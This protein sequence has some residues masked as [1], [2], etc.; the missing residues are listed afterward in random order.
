MPVHKRNEPYLYLYEHGILTSSRL[1]ECGGVQ[2]EGSFRDPHD[3]K[4]SHVRASQRSE[5]RIMR[6]WDV[7]LSQ[8]RRYHPV[9]QSASDGDVIA[10]LVVRLSV[11]FQG[12]VVCHDLHI[13]A[14]EQE[15]IVPQVTRN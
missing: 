4:Q 8:Q 10:A 9:L 13:Q 3:C 5:E 1:I 12:F 14:V 7:G 11:T 15:D 2:S 6:T